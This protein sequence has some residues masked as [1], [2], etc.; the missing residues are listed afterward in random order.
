MLLKLDNTV[1]PNKSMLVSSPKEKGTGDDG[2]RDLVM[3]FLL[4]LLY[5]LLMMMMVMTMIL[6]KGLDCW[7]CPVVTSRIKELTFQWWDRGDKV[8]E[9]MVIKSVKAQF[10]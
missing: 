5:L 3:M 8:E 9:R 6:G 2:G 4:L 10:I 1:G 7:C